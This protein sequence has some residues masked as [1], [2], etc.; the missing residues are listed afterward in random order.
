[1]A[2]Q[3]AF[4]PMEEIK[5]TQGYGKKSSTHKN[6]FALDIAGK[7]GGKDPIF[8][9]FDCKVTKLYQPKNTKKN[10]TTVWLTS[11]K[12]VLCANGYYGYLT[13]AITHPDE[14][15]KMKVGQKFKQFDFVCY[16]G[17]TGGAT[18]N[19]AHIELS[20][21][22]KAGWEV[23]NGDYVNVNRVRPEEYLFVIE[24][25]KVLKDTYKGKKYNFIKE[26]DITYVVY[27]VPSE[28]LLS[29]SKPNYKNSSVIKKGN[30][31]NGDE[32]IRF[33]K[34]GSMAY[35]YHFEIMGYTADKYLKK[36]KY[37]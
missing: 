17:K 11:T 24:Q 22:K 5:L 35:F 13:M 3:R 6:S 21:G 26:S 18:G 27:N 29:H 28:P 15:M 2:Y 10:A 32:V 8:A 25:G 37:N 16:E 4:L 36:K 30:L 7:D 34:S 14:I 33:Y 12:K 31:Y 9:P 23:V 1:M 20:K 19:H